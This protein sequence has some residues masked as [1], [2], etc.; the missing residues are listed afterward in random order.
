MLYDPGASSGGGQY[1]EVDQGNSVVV[2][3]HGLGTLPLAS[4]L[5]KRGAQMAFL[6]VMY[7]ICIDTTY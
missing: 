7:E 1:S 4:L 3:L 6:I 5:T 2:Q